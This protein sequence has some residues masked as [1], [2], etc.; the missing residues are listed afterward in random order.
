MIQPLTDTGLISYLLSITETERET[1]M[2]GSIR[3]KGKCPECEDSFKQVKKIG[4]ICPQ[5]KI[6]PKRFY[7]DLFHKGQRIR[8]FSD[9]AGQVIDSYQRALNLLSHINY[10]IKNFSFDPINYIK[11]ELEKFW[12]SNLL[13]RFLNHKLNSMAPSY[14]NDFKRMV[15][16]AKEYFKT[17]DVRELRKIDIINYKEY[18]EDK[19]KISNKTIK[20]NI[21]VFKTFLRYLMND[22]EMI[23][24][25]PPFPDIEI[26]QYNFKWLSHEDQIALFELIPDILKPVFAFLMLTGCRP[27][28]ARALK[29][30]N[31]DLKNHFVTI[32]ATYSG[33][34]FR[35]KRKGKRSHSVT[36]PIHPE[37]YDFMADRVINNHPEAFVFINPRT[38]NPF[39][40][41]TLQKEWAKVR[42][43]A[44]IDTS[45][46]LY[47]ATR[48]SF[49]SQLVNSGSTIYKVSKLLGHS[50]VKMTEKYAHSN[51]ESLKTEVEKLSLKKIKT[52]TRLSPEAK[53]NF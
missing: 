31:A 47:D 48:H 36:I 37:L 43:K 40:K 44:K 51:I 32:S 26:Q 17:K 35:E 42:E 50:S 28:E 13:E 38:G 8:I 39:K 11:A 22:L 10:E 53:T 7:I 12:T 1:D 6:I 25:V 49:A 41:N 14:Q 23:D 4:F 30:K 24:K 18:L 5:C 21:D 33:N 2:K 46:R 27:S 19:F 16:T 34:V 3:A 20:N 15:Y 9:K 29:C 52:V 45:L